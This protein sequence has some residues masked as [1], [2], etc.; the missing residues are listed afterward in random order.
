MLD[1]LEAGKHDHSGEGMP[2]SV[3]EG[4]YRLIPC[5]NVSFN[6]FDD[7]KRLTYQDSQYGQLNEDSDSTDDVFWL[8]YWDCLPCCYPSLHSDQRSVTMVSDFYTDRQF[9]D[10]GMYADYLHPVG[11]EHEMMLCLRAPVGR[12]RRLIFFRGAGS[13]FSERDRLLL[14]LLRPHLDELYQRRE[15]SRRGPQSLTSRQ[16]E[17][18]RLVAAGYTNSE[19]ATRLYLSPTTVRKH[20]ENIFQRLGV[21]SRTAAV[22]LAFPEGLLF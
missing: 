9:H 2:S 15:F 7:Q 13:N 17:L 21:A 12:S 20:L 14:S 11:F 16:R 19:I 4:A 5:D 3:L 10:T 8:H 18:L 1:L 22:T 6:E